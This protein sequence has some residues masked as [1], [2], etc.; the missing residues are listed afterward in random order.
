MTAS[1]VNEFTYNYFNAK[2]EYRT[3]TARF[4]GKREYKTFFFGPRGNTRLGLSRFL[5][6]LSFWAYFYHL[7]MRQ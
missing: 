4:D 1:F 6:A 2:R 3:W 7:F 5:W